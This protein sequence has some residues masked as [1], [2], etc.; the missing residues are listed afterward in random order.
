MTPTNKIVADLL[1]AGGI[2]AL[3]GTADWAVHVGQ[4]PK[5]PD[6]CITI[7]EF[8]VRPPQNVSDRANYKPVRYP[9]VQI[10]IR[11]HV[12]ATVVAK[13][14][15]CN[16]ILRVKRATVT[17][18]VRYMGYNQTTDLISM[19]RDDSDRA[20]VVTSWECVIRETS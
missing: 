17:D 11:G 1:V 15:L 16:E 4:E 2:G 10:R 13:L 9:G 8:S 14:E 5:K 3:S 20:I 18:G 12:Y 19:G 6:N 7:L